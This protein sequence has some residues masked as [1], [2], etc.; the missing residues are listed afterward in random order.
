MKRYAGVA[1]AIAA[2]AHLRRAHLLEAFLIER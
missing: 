1:I 2:S